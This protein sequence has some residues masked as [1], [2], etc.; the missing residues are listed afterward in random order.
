MTSTSK[1]LTD[2]ELKAIINDPKFFKSDD[3]NASSADN[4]FVISEHETESEASKTDS[5]TDTSVE[6]NTSIVDVDKYVFVR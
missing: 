1:N 5:D 4:E 3:E 2:T 6:N